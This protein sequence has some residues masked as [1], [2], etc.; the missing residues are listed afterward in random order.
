MQAARFAPHFSRALGFALVAAALAACGG[1]TASPDAA[2]ADVTPVDAAPD[3]APDLVE[4]DKPPPQSSLIYGPCRADAE[5]A[6]GL[7][8][9][10]E[11]AS[12][13]SGGECN[14]TCTGDKDCVLILP[15]GAGAVDGWCPP[16]VGSAPRTCVRVC[17]NG[18]DCERPE[19]FT[20]RV[21]N[22]GT[23]TEV[24]ACIHVCSETSCINGNVC[25]HESGRCRP[26]GTPPTGRTLG[27]TCQPETR[28]GS[29]TPPPDRICRSGLCQP[30]FNPD[31]R[32][33]PFYT[34]WNGGY[35]LSRCILPEG[36]NSSTFWG[37]P[38]MTVPLPQANCPMG[39]VCL[40]SS[41][42]ARGD[43]GSCYQGCTTNTDCRASDGYFC[44]RQIQ[45]TQTTSRRFANGFCVPV[46]CT[47][48]ATPCPSGFSCRRNTNGSGS[49]IPAM[50]ASP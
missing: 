24:R 48:A 13:I 25:D 10:T 30:D 2:T 16:A 6:E 17:A 36:F 34:G 35:C 33:N 47:T 50:M 7:T 31:S 20:C 1:E 26:M 4:V 32:G 12:G 23:L 49:C 11:A 15:D 18:V 27:Q 28:T 29:P 39:G 43:L 41:S 5:C 37:K 3:V 42:Y 21:Y 22:A 19:A 44:Q 38:G 46:N 45:L 9:R 40:P 14:R 8:C